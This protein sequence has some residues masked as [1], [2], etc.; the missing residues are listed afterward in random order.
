MAPF[1]SHVDE[2]LGQGWTILFTAARVVVVYAVLLIALR[3]VGRRML[4]QMTPFDLLTLLLLSNVVQN[5]MIGPDNSLLGGLAG[6]VVLLLLNG[7]VSHRTRLRRFVEGAPVVLITR[8]RVMEEHLRREGILLDE[9]M[10]A[11]REHGIERIE[12]VDT[13]ILE[14]DGTISVIP[15]HTPTVHRVRKVRSSR[16]R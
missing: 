3:M 15:H 7:L 8:G 5:A 1:M 12:E 11:L 2:A 14:M 9:L 13:A 16:N 4:G 6:A 10:A